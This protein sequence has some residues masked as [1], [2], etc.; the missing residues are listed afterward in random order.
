MRMGNKEGRTEKRGT[1]T[2]IRK[3]SFQLPTHN[4]RL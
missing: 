2:K 1:G 4:T 3:G